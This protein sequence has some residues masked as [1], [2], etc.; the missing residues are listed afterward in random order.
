MVINLKKTTLST[1]ENH[2]IILPPDTKVEPVIEEYIYRS[3]YSAEYLHFDNNGRLDGFIDHKSNMYVLNSEYDARKEICEQLHEIFKSHDFIWSNQSYTTLA[4]S[5]FKHM[6]G[7]L[8]ESQYNTKTREIIDDNYPRALQWCS[9]DP[10]PENLVS[11]DI[12]KCYPSIL[13]NN[14][15]PIPLYAIHD[16]TRPFSEH[17]LTYNYGE[18]YIDVYV[19]NSWAKGMK[20]EAGFY[21]KRLVQILISGFKMPTS[22][23]KHFIRSRKKH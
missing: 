17:D 20:I 21:S 22:N 9:T 15:E 13:I 4:S 2:V 8:L 18:Y 12:C 11:L 3:Q 23:V 14:K 1:I 7:Y 19:F 6:R 10:V 16:I 5:L